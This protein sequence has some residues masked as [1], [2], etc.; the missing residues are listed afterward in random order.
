[1]PR[2]KVHS[3]VI[4]LVEQQEP[5]ELERVEQGPEVI[6]RSHRFLPFLWEL[7]KKFQQAIQI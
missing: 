7:T 2:L 1:M 6:L 4:Q 3:S 5:L